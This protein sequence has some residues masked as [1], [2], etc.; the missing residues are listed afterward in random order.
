RRGSGVRSPRAMANRRPGA[1]CRD[2]GAVPLVLVRLLLGLPCPLRSLARRKHRWRARRPDRPRGRSGSACRLLQHAAVDEREGGW[3]RSVHACL[4][5]LL[6]DQASSRGSAAAHA[7][8]HA[9]R[10]GGHPAGQPRARQPWQ[11]GARGS[12]GERSASFAD[13]HPRARRPSVLLG[14]RA[15]IGRTAIIVAGVE[16]VLTA[17]TVTVGLDIYAHRRVEEVGGVNVWG[18]RGAVAPQRQPNDIRI[19]VVGGTP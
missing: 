17:L 2:G 11:S 3:A 10:F 4:L 16:A 5:A 7:R 8:A 9:W 6:S 18:Y 1:A 14:A 19:V 12:G 13:H 15:M